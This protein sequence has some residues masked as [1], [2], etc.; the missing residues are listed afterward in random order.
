VN[1]TKLK[2]CRVSALVLW[3]LALCAFERQ[4]NAQEKPSG[5]E[6][7][8]APASSSMASAGL[9][10][11]P[12]YSADLWTRQYLSGDWGGL[13]T[14]LADKGI[15]VGLEWNQYVQ[16][17]ADGGRNRATEYGGNVDYTLNLDLMRMGVL[18][19]ALI[20]FR[21]ESRYG[22]SVNG[23]AG[24]ILPVNSDA[25]FPITAKP[26]QD[27]GITITDLNYTQFLSPHLGLFVGKLDTLDGDPNE[28]ASGRGTSQFMNA[29]FL[30][31]PAMAL[32]L[33]YS[34]LGAGVVLMPIPPGPHGGITV[35]STVINT[36]DSSTRT[37]FDDFGKGTSWTTEADFQYR[38]GQL[39]GG[40]NVGALYS[41]NQHF[42]R[43]N[44]RLV[45]QPG[46]GLVVPTKDSTWAVYWSAWQYLFTEQPGKRPL[47][48][49]IGEP[50]QRGIGLFAR[51]GFADKETNPVEWAVSG[52]V[53][54]RGLIP[55]RDN[56]CF[57]LGY[58]Y[59][60]IQTLRLSSPLG[61]KDS[62]QGFECFYNIAIT[63]ACHLTLDLQVVDSPQKRL[64]TA[65]VLGL[66]SSFDF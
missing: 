66:R 14:N 53:G 61:I 37:G 64:P 46:Q 20:K 3:V 62:S 26:D 56:D 43:L 12:D 7:Q 5:A 63:P 35:S 40:M 2:F 4:G 34:T 65:T 23:A 44:T 16:G 36:A 1:E 21:A 33:P 13:R 42:A 54:G 25:F 10:P 57:G 50:K 31:N 47:E 24:P 52:G 32:R 8:A 45:F 59:N 17:V 58:Y 9:L 29:N 19:G 27:I 22:L 48:Q 18:P 51:F 49:L 28:F 30:F 11:V 41:F 15:Q 55:S 39:P 6:Q 60:S 38:L